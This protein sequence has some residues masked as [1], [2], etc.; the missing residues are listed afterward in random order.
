MM[1]VTLQEWLER[2]VPVLERLASDPQ[3]QMEYLESIG[4][5]GSA[6]E[7]ALEFDDVYQPAR[8]ALDDSGYSAEFRSALSELDLQLSSMS[9]PDHPLLWTAQG[10]LEAPQW[11]QVRRM[12]HRALLLMGR[13][14]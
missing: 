14:E 6:D 4:V 12:A 10:L 1:I 11:A 8:H 9:G 5:G 7:L 3:R 13:Q 2:L